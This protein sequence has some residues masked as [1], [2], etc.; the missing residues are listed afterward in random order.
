MK[1]S[2]PLQSKPSKTQYTYA[3]VFS[4]PPNTSERHLLVSPI[5]T[6]TYIS[7]TVAE[8][9][10]FIGVFSLGKKSVQA[11]SVEYGG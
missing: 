10:P 7:S 6:V 4:N 5:A 11:K 1:L 8:R 3:S 2:Y 9:F